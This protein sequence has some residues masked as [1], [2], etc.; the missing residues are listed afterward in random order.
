MKMY[1]IG[2]YLRIYNFMVFFILWYT[3]YI[4][5][6]KSK[7][8]KSARITLKRNYNDNLLTQ[9]IFYYRRFGLSA[10]N[11]QQFLILIM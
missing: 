6:L 9:A 3:F 1:F 10:Y 2:I 11:M 4:R 5:G 7:F 8:N